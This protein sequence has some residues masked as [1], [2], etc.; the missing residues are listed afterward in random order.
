MEA[1]NNVRM[2]YSLA[3]ILIS[4][5]Y[6]ARIFNINERFK[7][8]IVF[9]ITEQLLENRSNKII[10]NYVFHKKIFVHLKLTLVF[11]YRKYNIYYMQ[12]NIFTII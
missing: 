2:Q 8:K 1:S 3:D 12:F 11:L 4:L 9:L 6:K 7:I 5:H 10:L